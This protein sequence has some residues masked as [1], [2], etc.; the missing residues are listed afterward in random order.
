MLTGRAGGRNLVNTSFS[1]NTS[2]VNNA[3]QNPPAACPFKASIEHMRKPYEPLIG[4][5]APLLGEVQILDKTDCTRKLTGGDG[6]F[7]IV[8]RC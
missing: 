7:C 6:A 2:S 1:Q 4:K 8:G 3:T 5:I